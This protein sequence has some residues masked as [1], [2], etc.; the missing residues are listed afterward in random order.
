MWISKCQ[1]Q[2]DIHEIDPPWSNL[3][4][5]SAVRGFLARVE[6]VESRP[7]IVTPPNESTSNGAKMWISFVM[8]NARPVCVS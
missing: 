2:W 6:V 1:S 5:F 3:M 8:F 7:R 4:N